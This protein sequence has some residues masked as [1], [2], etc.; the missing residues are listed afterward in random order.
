MYNEKTN[1]AKFL[2]GMDADVNRGTDVYETPFMM[3]V[4]SDRSEFAKLLVENG[5]DIN[6][7]DKYGY[8]PLFLALFY[9]QTDV[10]KLLIEKGADINATDEEGYN[11]LHY[12][13]MTDDVE[14]IKL[15]ISKFD[16][17]NTAAK[18]GNLPIHIA[19][20]YGN[21]DI[22]K[23]L[24][25][26]GADIFAV[27][28]FN[29]T[30]WANALIFKN[31]KIAELLVQ[32]G[33]EESIFTETIKGN[34][35]KVKEMLDENPELIEQRI[36]NATVLNYAAFC[37]HKNILELFL[38]QGCDVKNIDTES[39]LQSA[40]QL[41]QVDIIKLLIDE[42]ADVNAKDFMGNTP[43]FW[44]TSKE[45]AEI[46][47][48]NGADL[49][50]KNEDGDTALHFILSHHGH[51]GIL[52]Y[53]VGLKNYIRRELGEKD[54]HKALSIQLE[55]AQ[56]LINNGADIKAKNNKGQTPLDVI[57]NWEHQ[58]EVKRFLNRYL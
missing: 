20:S 21:Y 50:N 1:I 4:Y 17:V 26:N 11:C 14:L 55:I 7:K 28:K 48:K 15:L 22:V 37:G 24:I 23:V 25:E 6:A 47:I 53:L 38:E 40:A 13:V 52:A 12:A 35:A 56:C 8:T 54:R 51:K 42:D 43:V 39:P 46:F 19:C 29:D 3:S 45:A 34:F 32:N 57:K 10:A 33:A 5:L 31:D 58:P 2:I 9:K 30:P 44:C 18:Y 41:N 49:N 36:G 27:T 16:T